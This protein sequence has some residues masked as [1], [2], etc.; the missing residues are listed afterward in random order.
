MVF[1]FAITIYAS[2][3]YKSKSGEYD[4]NKT[5]YANN[6]YSRKVCVYDGGKINIPVVYFKKYHCPYS[7]QYDVY[8]DRI[9]DWN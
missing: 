5:F 7:I 3:M 2:C 8:R 9:C 4:A 6:M 1:I